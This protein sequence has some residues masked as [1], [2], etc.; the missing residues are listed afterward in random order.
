M[1]GNARTLDGQNVI[2]CDSITINEEIIL[3]GDNGEPNNIIISDGVNAKWK[4]FDDLLNAGD[5]INITGTTISASLNNLS[6]SGSG[7]T[8]TPNEPYDGLTAISGVITNTTYTAGTNVA[9]SGSNVISATDTNTTYT[10]G[11]GLSLSVSN[12]FSL[13]AN[14][15]TNLFFPITQTG[16]AGLP[17]GC[18]YNDTIFGL[19]IA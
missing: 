13:N 15:S 18:L 12:E 11:S 10:A 7:I 14:P 19:T 6:L 1:S 16:N 2:E 9:I 3:D 17:T 8:L 4:L 5:G